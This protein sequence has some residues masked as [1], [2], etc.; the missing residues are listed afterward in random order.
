MADALDSRLDGLDREQLVA[1][2]RRLVRHDPDLEDLVHLPLPGEPPRVDV[3]QIRLHVTRIVS[4]IG[5]DWRASSRAETELWPIVTSGRQ[6]LD[7]GALEEARTVFRTTIETIL[8]HYTDFRDNESEV[9]GTVDRCVGGLGDCLQGA[10][11]SEARAGLLDEV[12]SVW[13]WD[14]V[15]Q[16]GYGMDRQARRILLEQTTADER[17]RV[18]D[19]IRAPLP[20]GDQDHG[21]RR[22][23]A[24]GEFVLELLGHELSD[25]ERERLYVEASL[26]EPLLALLFGQGREDEAV[27]AVR[28]ASARSVP[29]LADQL[30]AAGLWEE[31]ERAVLEH[32][33]LIDPE[34]RGLLRW[35]EQ[36]DVTRPSGLEDAAW[37][38]SRFRSSPTLGHYRRLR[39]L[40][41][42]VGRWP[43]ALRLV[44]G[45]KPD[46][47]AVRPIRARIFAE[48]GR[49]D[50]ALAI[51]A[52]L[53]DSAWRSTAADMAR[54]LESVDPEAAARL[55]QS[56]IARLLARDTKPSRKAA[57]EHQR[58]FDAL[59]ARSS[60]R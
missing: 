53:T 44:E 7:E 1:V 32:P 59:A 20:P 45:V 37:A 51:L 10:T 19:R 50:E 12:A 41:V 17:G 18:A 33:S 31:A 46:A 43:E 15:E 4:S 9:A 14:Q 24:G 49:I 30:V 5:W 28:R 54:S 23:Q 11:S 16:G 8:R 36:N 38:V 6:L 27:A 48:L 34:D 58:R 25:S 42:A 55:Y 39:E 2:V 56:L 13:L 29:K 60:E 35:L 26:S 52:D 47:K 40:A 22:R 21:E 3:E 57:A